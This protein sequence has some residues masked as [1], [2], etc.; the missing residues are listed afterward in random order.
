MAIELSTSSEH[1]ASGIDYQKNPDILKPEQRFINVHEQL[2]SVAGGE[3]K[4]ELTRLQ[5]ATQEALMTGLPSGGVGENDSP[6]ADMFN[7]ESE[8]NDQLRQFNTSA[9]ELARLVPSEEHIKLVDD[10]LRELEHLEQ[11]SGSLNISD[12][13]C[14]LA[15]LRGDNQEIELIIEQLRRDFR[16]EHQGASEYLSRLAFAIK[17]L[18]EISPE[19]A[20]NAATYV[21]EAVPYL[22]V[23]GSEAELARQR[24][25]DMHQ[26]VW[27]AALNQYMPTNKLGPEQLDKIYSSETRRRLAFSMISPQRM[28][29][30]LSAA[31]QAEV[32]QRYLN[33]DDAELKAA[34]LVECFELSGHPDIF[35]SALNYVRSDVDLGRKLN[36]SQK[37]AMLCDLSERGERHLLMLG[38]ERRQDYAATAKQVVVELEEFIGNPELG[39]FPFTAKALGKAALGVVSPRRREQQEQDKVS[40][41]KSA[42]KQAKQLHSR[43][44]LE[45]ALATGQSEDMNTALAS[46]NRF[47][48]RTDRTE[49][50]TENHEALVAF[51]LRQIHILCKLG[52]V[53]LA[54]DY[55]QNNL[56]KNSIEE[57]IDVYAPD[58][59]AA[60]LKAEGRDKDA[61]RLVDFY[62][63]NAALRY[64]QL[65]PLPK[66]NNYVGFLAN[67]R[68]AVQ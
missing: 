5:Q 28:N 11:S 48:W 9:Y 29:P 7:N 43:L 44:L 12:E 46:L 36:I 25:D 33:T 21:E 38:V 8:L 54:Q 49:S 23:E 10:G 40:Q 42:E 30:Q 2:I 18:A 55:A 53:D 41:L 16:R 6:T 59:I 14:R 32:E 3:L 17:S 37:A 13:R 39:R 57:T 15:I 61:K 60:H 52:Q 26:K 62:V 67:S 19:T 35:N 64:A 58:V 22:E 68:R 27:R 65:P 63:K 24:L 31:M 50:E 45:V 4:D 47:G 66:V 1:A 20:F 34:R 51:R 56:L